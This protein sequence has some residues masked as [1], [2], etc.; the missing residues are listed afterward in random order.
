MT[1]LQT[2]IEVEVATRAV[3]ETYGFKN[4]KAYYDFR[5]EVYRDLPK[6][7]FQDTGEYEVSVGDEVHVVRRLNPGESVTI[8]KPKLIF[9][10]KQTGGKKHG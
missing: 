10:R 2:V 9:K 6:D 3:L 7:F 8:T 4:K 5:Q 1:P